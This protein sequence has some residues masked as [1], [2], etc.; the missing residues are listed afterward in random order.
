MAKVEMKRSHKLANDEAKKRVDAL[1]ATLQQKYG[2]TGTWS[3]NRYDFKRT[4]VTGCVLLSEGQVAVEVNLSMLLS[5]IK[6][7][8]EQAIREKLDKEFA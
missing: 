7:K 3:G 4:G 8:V 1:A 5:P 6:S 2:L